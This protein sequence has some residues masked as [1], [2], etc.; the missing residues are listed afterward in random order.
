MTRIGRLASAVGLSRVS[1]FWKGA[2]CPAAWRLNVAPPRLGLVD[3]P[4]HLGTNDGNVRMMETPS[5]DCFALH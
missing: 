4:A 1:T 2:F 3:T 5:S